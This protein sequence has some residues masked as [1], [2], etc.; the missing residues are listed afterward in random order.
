MRAKIRRAAGLRRPTR[1]T[2]L[3]HRDWRG[4]AVELDLDLACDVPAEPIEPGPE[5]IHIGRA[6]ERLPGRRLQTI[7]QRRWR[8]YDFGGP[9]LGLVQCETDASGADLVRAGA[10]RDRQEREGHNHF[11]K[12]PDHGFSSGSSSGI[13][14][15]S[16]AQ[17]LSQSSL[18]K[19]D[20]RTMCT[21]L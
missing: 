21:D 10:R 16:E 9:G 4:D 5:G 19:N 6:A 11:A 13:S 8:R 14:T 18:A 2:T 3:S 7:E 1:R 17:K 20:A 12:R 15:V